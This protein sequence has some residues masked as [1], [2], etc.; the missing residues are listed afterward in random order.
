MGAESRE[1][2]VQPGI[3]D[4]LRLPKA[5]EP[6][7]MPCSDESRL[8]RVML[9][10][11]RHTASHWLTSGWKLAARD[12]A[13]PGG[14]RNVLERDRVPVSSMTPQELGEVVHGPLH[15]PVTGP[16]V[17]PGRW[18]PSDAHQPHPQRLVEFLQRLAP[19]HRPEQLRGNQ[20][21]AEQEPAVLYGPKVAL[22]G[23]HAPPPFGPLRHHPQPAI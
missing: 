12:V 17:V 11:V 1:R 6:E 15:T 2:Q 14:P 23:M 7:T 20:S 4:T 22:P 19:T 21:A 9:V 13:A 8:I 3:V 16:S 5:I 10:L 18:L